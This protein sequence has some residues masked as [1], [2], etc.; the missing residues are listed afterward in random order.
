MEGRTVCDGRRGCRSG[1]RCVRIGEWRDYARS[2]TGRVGGEWA[3]R[4][5]GNL[6]SPYKLRAR[7]NRRR[8]P[9]FS[10]PSDRCGRPVGR[11]GGG[12][13]VVV[14][15]PYPPSSPQPPTPPI[16]PFLFFVL[17]QI[18]R[19]AADP[20]ATVIVVVVVVDVPTATVAGR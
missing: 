2:A 12:G 17:N 7:G 19:A 6:L 11:G 9:R 13:G 20:P 15:C 4:A 16:G 14:T 18:R 1:K 10:V 5:A 3:I 8:R